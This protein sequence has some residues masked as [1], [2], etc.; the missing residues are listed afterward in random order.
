VK[1]QQSPNGYGGPAEPRNGQLIPTSRWCH[2]ISAFTQL[3]VDDTRSDNGRHGVAGEISL[4][5]A[6][7]STPG[8]VLHTAS[9]S[10]SETEME[11]QF[12]AENRGRGSVTK[13]W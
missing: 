8:A 13:K 2:K 10:T 4:R 3:F 6:S 9:G 5:V 11:L 1:A 12:R 7:E